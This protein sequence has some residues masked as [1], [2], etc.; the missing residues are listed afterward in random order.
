MTARYFVKRVLYG[1]VVVFGVAT[2]V[3]VA[4][5]LLSDPARKMLPLSASHQQYVTFR[6][7][8]GLDR[9][10]LSQFWTFLRD[11]SHLDFGTS[12]SLDSSAAHAVAS[13]LPH[14]FELVGFG[15]AIALLIAI[16]LGVLSATRPGSAADSATV[17]TSLLGLSLPQFWLGAVLILFFAVQLHG[18]PTSG[19]GTFKQLIMP[20]A[21]A[22]AADRGARHANGAVDG[23]RRAEQ[24]VRDRSARQRAEPALHPRA[25]RPPER[26]RADVVVHQSGDR[27]SRLPARPSSSRACSRIRAS[28]ISPSRHR[29]RTT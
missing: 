10:L 1:V 14:T 25:P 3:F 24:A 22:C 12:I 20:A 7:Q 23:D 29:R 27:R 26:A 17:T 4:T 13:R 21:H 5:H 2:V 8:L 15:L 18:L 6:Q 9:P 11:A 19:A 16:P 28:A